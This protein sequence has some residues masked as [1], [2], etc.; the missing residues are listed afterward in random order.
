MAV[1]PHALDISNLNDNIVLALVT[2]SRSSIFSTAALNLSCVA[3]S[4][5][6]PDI[7]AHRIAHR[8]RFSLSYRF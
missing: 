4:T 1:T 7:I 6:K 8:I 5:G 3:I 2:I